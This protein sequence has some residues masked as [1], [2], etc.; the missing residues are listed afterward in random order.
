MRVRLKR[1]KNLLLIP[2]FPVFNTT[3][4]FRQPNLHRYAT[5][6]FHHQYCL[7]H[8]A[9]FRELD[10]RIFTIYLLRDKPLINF[11]TNTCLLLI[12]YYIV[13]MTNCNTLEAKNFAR[14]FNSNKRVFMDNN[15]IAQAFFMCCRMV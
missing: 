3:F 8:Q 1:L 14:F 13:V 15:M 9:E 10:T 5:I 4:Y 2:W 12:M 7:S 6:L 11:L